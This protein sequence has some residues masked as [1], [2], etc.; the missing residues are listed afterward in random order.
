MAEQSRIACKAAA[1]KVMSAGEASE[2]ILAGDNVGMSGFTGA[3]YPKAVPFEL[4][5]RRDRSDRPR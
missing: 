5:R 3:G 4:A 1:G 2:F